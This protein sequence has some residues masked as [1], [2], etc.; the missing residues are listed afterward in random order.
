MGFHIELFT[1]VFLFI[2]FLTAIATIMGAAKIPPFHK[3]RDKWIKILIGPLIVELGITVIGV[4]KSYHEHPVER[5]R[6]VI[7]YGDFIQDWLNTLDEKSKDCVQVYLKSTHQLNSLELNCRKVAEHFERKNFAN[8]REG[9]G[10]L[11]LYHGKN[12]YE[13]VAVYR[14]PNEETPT[15]LEVLGQDAD[16]D[17]LKLS[18][19]QQEGVFKR[20]DGI[21]L[22]RP[23][24][25]FEPT[26]FQ[27][28]KDG[29]SSRY[30]AK[31][32]GNEG[33]D[34]GRIAFY[35]E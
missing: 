25:T 14:F 35:Q 31:L 13:G 11:Y 18:F 23:Y 6:L 30:E 27:L 19:T 21:V 9:K 22:I 17:S 34:Y 15:I 24:D 12:S 29:G 20:Q 32:L 28:K 4:Y 3:M 5:Y 2:F 16:K 1:Y 8:K 10:H 26:V 7:H 33:V